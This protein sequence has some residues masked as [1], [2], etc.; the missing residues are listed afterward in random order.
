[1]AELFSKLVY[2]P[3]LILHLH[4]PVKFSVVCSVLCSHCIVCVSE[5]H[6]VTQLLAAPL[7]H[8]LSGFSI[9][10]SSLSAS[11]LPHSVVEL[12]LKYPVP[13]CQPNLFTFGPT[14]CFTH[15]HQCT[16]SPQAAGNVQFKLKRICKGKSSGFNGHD[17]MHIY[18]IVQHWETRVR[19]QV[20]FS[21][22]LFKGQPDVPLNPQLTSI[23]SH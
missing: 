6:A 14:H 21:L 17:R 15:K 3:T 20:R 19:D 16:K 23:T 12:S 1:M 10:L 4:S 18:G 2:S 8:H 11:F 5:P 13:T 9:Y 22:L 7:N